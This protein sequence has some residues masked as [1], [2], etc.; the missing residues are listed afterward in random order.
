MRPAT[1]L[2][3][4]ILLAPLPACSSS[5]NPSAQGSDGGG[6][7]PHDASLD[8][9]AE[10]DASDASDDANKS[11]PCAATF[12]SALTNAFGRVDG[13]VVAVVPAGDETCAMPNSTHLVIQ[14]LVQG[15]VYR[16]VVDVLSD[17]PTDSGSEAVMYYEMDGPLAAGAWS[18]GWHPGVALDYVSTL[19]VHT[20][21]FTLIDEADVEARIT[22]EIQLGAHIS[23][24]AT[25]DDEPSSAHLVHRNLTNQDGAIVFS[26]DTAP[27]YFLIQFQDQTF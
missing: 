25:S 1:P 6:A 3:V 24:F 8:T 14:V 7:S 21:Q 4:L 2:L 5:G 23:V 19:A 12:G 26:P 10:D 16:M 27:H 9:S 17:E 13:T 11:A 20:P 22:S 15:A 18:E